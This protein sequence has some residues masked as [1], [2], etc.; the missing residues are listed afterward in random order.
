MSR[1]NDFGLSDE[2]QRFI[3]IAVGMGLDNLQKLGSLMPM[4]LSARGDEYGLCALAVDADDLMEAATKHV[5][6][7]PS[8]TSFYAL[9]FDGKMNVE[10][11]VLNAVI[12]QAGE[13]GEAHGHMVYQPYD[14][15]TH[16]ADG[17]PEYAGHVEQ[18]LSR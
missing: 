1:E 12:V 2:L 3:L 13:R 15:E 8:E 7:L 4:I 5:V 11:T 16:E 9:V 10:G 14:L 18:L 6:E 17:A